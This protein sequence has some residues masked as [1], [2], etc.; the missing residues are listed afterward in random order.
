MNFF[1]D[2]IIPLPLSN[3][4]TYSVSKE[5]FDFLDLGH[6]VGVPFG[7]NKLFTGII[8]KKHKISVV[9]IIV[10]TVQMKPLPM[11]VMQI[12]H[13]VISKKNQQLPAD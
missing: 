13:G 2:V 7:K 4:F 9:S 3:A 12:C 1:I 8:I 10:I 5:E 11:A 6:R